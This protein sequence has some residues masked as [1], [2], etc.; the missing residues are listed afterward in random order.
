MLEIFTSQNYSFRV[1]LILGLK[2]TF[3]S[4]PY[5]EDTQLMIL[6]NKASLD[7]VPNIKLALIEVRFLIIS[8]D[9]I[10]LVVV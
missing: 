10:L 6:I 2:E 4:I 9:H 1:G 7:R 5:S 8:E 3:M